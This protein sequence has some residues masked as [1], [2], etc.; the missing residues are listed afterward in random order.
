MRTTERRALDWLVQAGAE[1]KVS[2]ETRTTRL[3]AKSWLVH[4]D[5]GYSTAYV[6]SSNLSHAAL[7]DGIEWNVRIAQKTAAAAYDKLCATIDSLWND[8]RF[9]SY[10]PARDARRFDAAV[11]ATKPN[12]SSTA[13]SSY[14]AAISASCWSA[15]HDRSAGSTCAHRDDVR[16]RF[17]RLG[18]PRP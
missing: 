4:R 5:T 9:E 13:L 15:A 10:D 7:V 3:H 6:G 2:Y 12:T 1:A 8:D 16:H 14:S 11:Q 17:L 18:R